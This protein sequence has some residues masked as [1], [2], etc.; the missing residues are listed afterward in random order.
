MK[1][2]APTASTWQWLH[3]SNPQSR[4]PAEKCSLSTL[5]SCISLFGDAV[6]AVNVLHSCTFHHAQGV[7][8]ELNFNFLTPIKKKTIFDKHPILKCLIFVNK[9]LEIKLKNICVLVEWLTR[10]S[11]ACF[12][13]C[14][15]YVCIVQDY[16]DESR[17][18]ICNL[19]FCIAR[20]LPR[21]NAPCVLGMCYITPMT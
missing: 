19:T 7:Y 11:T 5:T 1:S 4:R 15:Y 18:L 10:P 20:I 2:T 3:L 21:Y 17:T 16:S 14:H 12:F 9:L 6:D 8:D 13:V